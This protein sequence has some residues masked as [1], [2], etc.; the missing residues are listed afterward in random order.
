MLYECCVTLR[1]NM[2]RLNPSEQKRVVAP[3]L[4]K[5][6]ENFK[7]SAVLELTKEMNI[8]CHLLIELPNIHSKNKFMNRFR[9]HTA[10]LGRHPCNQLVDYPKY[11]VYLKKSLAETREVIG[12]PVLVDYFCILGDIK[13]HGFLEDNGSSHDTPPASHR[14]PHLAVIV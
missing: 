5:I 11:C 6:F 4:H 3:L 9:S 12:D 8:H 1:P 10:V 13:H 7:V 14:P 2:Y